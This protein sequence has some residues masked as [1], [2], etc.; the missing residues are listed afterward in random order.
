MKKLPAYEVPFRRITDGLSNTMLQ[1]EMLQVPSDGVVDRR[2]RMWVKGRGSN[3]ISTVEAP[4]TSEPDQTRC[5]DN[6]PIVEAP[7][8]SSV[9]G[10]DYP[11][12]ILHAR[13]RHPGGVQVSYC[14][15]SATFISDS[16]ELAVW[17]S[18]GTKGRR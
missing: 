4:N 2:A 8:D 12:R 7:C 1:I 5:D 11:G 17:R 15:G 13:S 6:G 14:D 9:G 18:S 10:Q 3:Q 16:V